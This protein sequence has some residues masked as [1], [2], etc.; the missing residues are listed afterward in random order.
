MVFFFIKN[1]VIFTKYLYSLIQIHMIVITLHSENND[2]DMNGTI[3]MY[4]WSTI[5]MIAFFID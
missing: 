2:K 4:V 3:S 5:F 1:M